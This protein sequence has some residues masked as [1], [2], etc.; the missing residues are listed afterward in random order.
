MRFVDFAIITG[1]LEEF[2]VLRRSFPD[3]KEESDERQADVWYRGRI[4]SKRGHGYSVVATF[5]K[6]M[7]PVPATLLTQRLIERWD[8][9]YIILL[10][11]AGSFSKDVRLGDVIASQ[12]IFYYGPGKAAP[13]GIQYRPEGYPCSMVLIRQTQALTIETETMAPLRAEARSSAVKKAEAALGNPNAGDLDV[14]RSHEPKV[15]FGTVASGELVVASEAKQKELL[16]LHGKILGTEMESAGVLHAA[17]FSGDTPT[18]AIM[19]KG[20]SDHADH[21]KAHEDEKNYWRQLAIENSIRLGLALIGSGRIRPLRADEFGVDV[22][23]SSVAEVRNRIARAASPGVSFLGFP[24]LVLPR[25]PLS[26]LSITVEAITDDGKELK[27][28]DGL[29]EYLN[30]RNERITSHFPVDSRTITLSEISLGPVGLYLM[31]S[32]TAARVQF[33][34]SGP[35]G[36]QEI[37]LSLKTL[38]E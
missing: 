15:H 7:G 27:I 24:R 33:R 29:V 20:I 34:I 9:A 16:A 11:I 35:A 19:I 28:F 6:E 30:A 21:L 12:Q 4:D 1:L 17:F 25:G 5:Q 14:L 36:Q 3:L 10:G 38:R 2:E 26:R 31:L 37:G 22:T 23:R 18:P 32:G 8:P 13:A